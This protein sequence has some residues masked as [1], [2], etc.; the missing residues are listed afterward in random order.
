MADNKDR[1]VGVRM[2]DDE[3]AALDRRRAELA[4]EG[5]KALSRS[6]YIRLLLAADA[7]RGPDERPQACPVNPLFWH[8]VVVQ[9]RRIGTNLNQ[10]VASYRRLTR[11]DDRATLILDSSLVNSLRVARE[12]LASLAEECAG[13]HEKA[14]VKVSHSY[15]RALMRQ[16]AQAAPEPGERA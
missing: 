12:A 4:G 7:Q 3:L 11:E 15:A 6:D 13:V 2:C 16:A 5:R 14:G 9:I 1:F 10:A 8:A